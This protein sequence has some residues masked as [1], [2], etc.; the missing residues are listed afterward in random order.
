[1]STDSPDTGITHYS[2][3]ETGNLRFKIQNNKA[4]EY[5]Y[6]LLG[7]LENIL[8]SD[9]AQNVTMTYDSG[10]GANLKGRL[11]TVTDPSSF[12][13]YSYDADGNVEME[14]R[15]VNGVAFVTCYGYDDAGN[16]RTITYPTGHTV[17]YQPDATDPALIAGCCSTAAK[18]WPPT[19]PTPP[20]AL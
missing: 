1:M 9:N 3:D 2:Y 8:Y 18:P 11:S 17:D 15:T 5:R 10:A 13:E 19:S 12:V 20:S 7:R 14:T 4:I 6:D 16:L